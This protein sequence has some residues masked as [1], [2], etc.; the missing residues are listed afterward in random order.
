M[1]LTP[2]GKINRRALY[3]AKLDSA[4]ETTSEGTVAD[5]LQAQLI[6]IWEELLGRK[7]VGIRDNFFELGGHSLL[8]A[9][10]MHRIKQVHGKSLPLA[11][12]LEAPTV[13][14]LAAVLRDG[15]S[16]RWSSLVPIQPEGSKPPFFCVHGV[17][18]NIVGF[19]ELGKCMKPD[20]PFYG[21]QSQGLNTRYARHTSIEEMAS[22][23]LNEIRTVQPTGP[24]HLG[25]FSLGGLVAYEM[26]CQLV[27]RGE[28]VSLVVLFD[29]YASNPTPLKES[30]LEMLLHPTW[31][32]LQQLPEEVRRKVRRTY[33][34]WRLPEDLK[35]VMRTN[36][37]AA[38]HYRLR[39][40]GGKA[41]LLRADDTWRASD[42]PYARWKELIAELETVKIPGAHMDILREPHVSRLAERLK[43]CIDAAALD[44]PKV[45]ARNAG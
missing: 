43:S 30:L 6:R 5:P 21:L 24:Y 18:G 31:A 12:L 22:H 4:P 29:T 28:E 15:E 44:E 7:P 17:G 3:T 45:L 10:L 14:Q 9:R 2:N 23:Y 36:A 41:I 42:D 8:A 20:Y 40:Y 19:R 13:E 1:P 35:K 38:E 33:L 11:V 39:P 32:P 37:Q 34:A 26:A 27:S 25:G 16:H